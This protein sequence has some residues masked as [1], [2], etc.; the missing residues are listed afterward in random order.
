M[1]TKSIRLRKDVATGAMAFALS[2][3]WLSL[4]CTASAALPA[5]ADA[6]RSGFT[7]TVRDNGLSLSDSGVRV[8]Y[9]HAVQR[10]VMLNWLRPESAQHGLRCAVEIRQDTAG[11]VNE[12]RIVE[13]CNADAATRESI[14]T[15]V[16]RAAPLP[17]EGFEAVRAASVRFVFRYDG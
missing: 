16:R 8:A 3:S 10:A 4:A 17:H 15:A 5:I 2:A 14:A 12:L 6:G 9:M 11:N 7:E 1:G 13:P